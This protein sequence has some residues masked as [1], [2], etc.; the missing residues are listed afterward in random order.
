MTRYLTVPHVVRI[1]DELVCRVP[2]MDRGK[3]DGALAA[4][5]QSAFECDAYP[6]LAEKAGKLLESVSRAHA[7]QDGNKRTAWLCCVTFLE[8]NGIVVHHLTQMNVADVV[9]AIAT[10]HHEVAK[11]AQWLNSVMEGTVESFWSF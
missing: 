1:H 5:R 7:F 6:T 2:L 3:L 8:I 10:G 9:E 4:P 11:I